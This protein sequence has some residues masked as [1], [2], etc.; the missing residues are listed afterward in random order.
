MT[1]TT[2]NRRRALTVVAAVPAALALAVP[3]LAMPGEDAE[4]RQLWAKYLVQLD[5][6]NKACATVSQ[7]RAAYDA[8]HAADCSALQMAAHNYWGSSAQRRL[9]K[10]H[11]LDPLYD[12]CNRE[13]RKHLRIVKAIRKAKAESL[14]GIGVKLSAWEDW[15][16]ISDDEFAGVVDAVR[17]DIAGL[18]GDDFIKATDRLAS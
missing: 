18:I 17:R 6:L 10:K 1:Q 3:A 12:A 9:W 16:H 2:M 11:G 7:R 13:H 4:L 15:D 8:D 14:F 5:P